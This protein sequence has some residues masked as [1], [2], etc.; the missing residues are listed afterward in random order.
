ML[1]RRVLARIAGNPAALG[2]SK[3]LSAL[4]LGIWSAKGRIPEEHVQ[5]LLPLWGRYFEKIGG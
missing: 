4:K 5:E 2:E 3:A 1:I